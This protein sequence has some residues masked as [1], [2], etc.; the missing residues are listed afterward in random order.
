M[1]EA[2][3]LPLGRRVALKVLPSAASLDPRQRQRFQVEA[4]AAALLHHEHIVPVYGIGCDQGIHFFAM[5]FIDGRSLREVIDSL[6]GVP[7][8]AEI[9][10]A[11]HSNGTP[12]VKIDPIQPTAARPTGSSLINRQHCQ[13]VAQLGLQAALALEH[14][15][16]IGV[17]HRDIKPSNLLVDG[18]EHL[19]VA[20]FGLARLPH[21]DHDLTRTGDLVGT[22]RYMSPEQVRGERGI[23]DARTD[24]YALG[25]TLYELLT[26]RPAFAANDRHELLRLILDEEPARPRRLSGSIPRD[27]DTIITKAMEKEPSARYA[28]ARAMADD[29]TRFLADQPIR[30]GA[31]VLSTNRSSGYAATAPRSWP[32]PPRCS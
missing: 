27:L 29:L 5:Q 21:H 1:Y 19:W 3:Q 25:V 11:E 12:T 10:D 8:L 6:R 13:L 31:R 26:L 28:S 9:G 7:T 15:H 2:E 24:I 14:A 32:R 4:Q 22:L 16:E 20:D 23:V 17:I 30:R 18:R